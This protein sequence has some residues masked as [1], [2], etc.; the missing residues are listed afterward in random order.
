MDETTFWTIIETASRKS[1]GDPDR[2]ADDVRKQLLKLPPPE[3]EA[4]EHLLNDKLDAAN[5]WDL[6]GAAYLINGGCSDDGFEYFRG[7]LVSC[8]RAVYDAAIDDPDSL[9][10]IV[11]PEEAEDGYECEPLLYVAHEVYKELAD[12]EMAPG[13]MGRLR[14]PRGER[15]DFDD[16]DEIAK[17]LPRLAL[18]FR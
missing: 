1:K 14:E 15:W 3:I 6:W 13:P 4:F 7:W 9:A 11:D 12:K 16:Q 17:R 10:D 5:S 8:G 18:V 2:A